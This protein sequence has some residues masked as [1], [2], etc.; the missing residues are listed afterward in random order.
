M[1][2]RSHFLHAVSWPY[3]PPS[4]SGSKPR[5][6]GIIDAKLRSVQSA[7][8]YRAAPVSK[9]ID[10]CT[11]IRMYVCMDACMHV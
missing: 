5:L 6:Q 3:K 2:H 11:Y 8:R 4:L 7:D 1:V 10:V 9:K